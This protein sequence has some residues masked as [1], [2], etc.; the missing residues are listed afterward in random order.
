MYLLIYSKG[1]KFNDIIFELDFLC[2][3]S[4]SD[5]I[6]GWVQSEEEVIF[7]KLRADLL[8]WDSW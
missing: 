7:L 3:N 5:N 6:F 1:P 8:L 4:S 2:N